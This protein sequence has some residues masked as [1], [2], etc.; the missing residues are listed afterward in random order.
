MS[1]MNQAPTEPV[2]FDGAPEAEGGGNS[3]R[4]LLVLGGAAVLVVALGGFFLLRSGGSGGDTG[5]VAVV[6]APSS[7]QPKATPSASPSD[8]ATKPPVYHQQA[9][10][11]PFKPLAAEK[12]ATAQAPTSTASPVSVPTS[13]PSATAPTSYQVT[14]KSASTSAQTATLWVNGTA[15]PDV[16]VGDTFASAFRLDVVAK[17]SHG[18]Y[19]KLTYGDVAQPGKLY[20]GHTLVG[21]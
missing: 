19:V 16:A 5:A 15:Y 2:P 12:P 18:T 21:P 20:V 6:V 10:R 8:D 11:N 1:D 14:L 13:D 3:R 17:D 7:G 4:L 9:G